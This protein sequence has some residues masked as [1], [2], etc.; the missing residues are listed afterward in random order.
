VDT[1]DSDGD[2]IL[3]DASTFGFTEGVRYLVE[4]GADVN[5]SSENGHTPLH[6]ASK[7]GHIE[8]VRALLEAGADVNMSTTNENGHTPLHL[9]SGEGHIEVVRALLEAGAGTDVRRVNG[10]GV[11]PISFACTGKH[12]EIFR[13]LVEAGGDVDTPDAIGDTA[14]HDASEDGFTEG[15][16]YLVE[17]GADVNKRNGVDMSPL[18]YALKVETWHTEQQRQALAQIA[19]LLREAGAQEPHPHELENLEESEDEV[20]NEDDH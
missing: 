9:A 16:R 4:R 13:A 11:T 1:P 17:R 6:L 5:K 8:V 18:F 15:V 14:L 7:V 19:A 10:H 3:H 12:M 20:D 2:T